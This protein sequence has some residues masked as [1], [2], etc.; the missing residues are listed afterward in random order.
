MENQPYLLLL[1]ES[2]AGNNGSD[3]LILN[4]TVRTGNIIDQIDF[5]LIGR[6]IRDGHGL[7]A[8]ADNR[9]MRRFL[10]S[11]VSMLIYHRLPCRSGQLRAFQPL[12]C[13]NEAR[14]VCSFLAMFSCPQEPKG[15]NIL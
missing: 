9:K 14:L 5:C 1:L 10:N 11:F 8:E 2:D 7:V 4:S 3:Q 6:F 12:T 13:I 15:C